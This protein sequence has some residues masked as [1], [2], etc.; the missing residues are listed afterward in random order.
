MAGARV[1]AGGTGGA[2]QW[3]RSPRWI[4]VAPLTA[5]ICVAAAAAHSI[6]ECR[7]SPAVPVPVPPPKA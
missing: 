1:I 5:A 2:S 6:A 7:P 3:S 4:T